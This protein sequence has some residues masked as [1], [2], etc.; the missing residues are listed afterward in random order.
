MNAAK[1]KAMDTAV[2]QTRGSPNR[3]LAPSALGIPN[4]AMTGRYGL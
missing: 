4:T 1:S 3:P 2:S